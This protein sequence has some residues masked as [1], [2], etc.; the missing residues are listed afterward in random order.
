MDMSKTIPRVPCH[1]SITCAGRGNVLGASGVRHLANTVGLGPGFFSGGLGVRLGIGKMCGGGHFTSHTTVNLTA[2]CSPARPICVRNGP[3][4]GKCFV[5]VGR[6]KSGTSPVSVN[7]TGPITVLR[8]G[9][10][11]SAICHD[12]NGTRVSCGFR[13]LPRLHTGLGLN[14]SMSGDGNSI[15]VTSGSPLAC[16]ANG[17][18]G[19][20][21]RGDRCARLGHGALLSF[22]LGCTGA[23]KIGCVSIVT[24]CS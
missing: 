24:N 21:N 16:Y 1:I 14:C 5:C 9:S 22:C 23:F 4:K 13:F 19:N 15:V 8:R 20:F 6:R 12:V 17:F 11:G 3:C 18:G 7:L 2:R 10:S